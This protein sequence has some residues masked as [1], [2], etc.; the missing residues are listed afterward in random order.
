MAGSRVWLRTFL[1]AGVLSASGCSA[2]GAAVSPAADPGAST[3]PASGLVASPAV[4]VPTPQREDASFGEVVQAAGFDAG[5]AAF[6]LLTS[7]TLKVV[8]GHTFVVRQVFAN[9]A[10]ATTAYHLFTGGGGTPGEPPKL[11][12]ARADS[13]FRFTLSYALATAEL[14]A[15]LRG[16]VLRGA[17]GSAP[18]QSARDAAVAAYGVA[19]AGGI[20]VPADEAPSSVDVVVDGVISQGKESAA[21][22]A[23]EYTGLDKTKAGTSW[24]AFKSGKKVWDALE[25][26][27]VVADALSRIRA[28][29]ACAANPTNELTRKEYEQDPAAK[30]DLLRRLDEMADEVTGNAAVLFVE[31]F[32]D[33]GAGLIKAAPWLG[34]ITGPATSYI[35]QNLGA[36]IEGRVREAE[37]LVPKC[38]VT[39][40]RVTGGGQV[41]VNGTIDSITSA[42]TVNG[43][44]DGFRVTFTFTPGDRTGRHGSV[45]YEGAG[46]NFTMSGSGTY[47][48][49]GDDPGP[50]TL[51]HSEYGCVDVGGCRNNSH[52]W[53]LTPSTGS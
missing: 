47:T 31:L 12:F 52:T 11:S 14:P 19:P 35:S 33:A 40:Y 20:R 4:S 30:K 13:A 48:I 16:Q 45:T 39:R 51:K 38:T 28:A 42:F 8:D 53:K 41:T 27:G 23:A 44:G 49:S 25:A 21:D 3:P 7:S 17:P 36:A 5:T 26:N 9:G 24:E 22:W 46:N 32:T 18:E 6:A 2:V 50:Y 29:R 15:D 37:Q 43:A 34:F 1:V 10:T